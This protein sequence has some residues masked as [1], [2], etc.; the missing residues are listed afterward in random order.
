MSFRTQRHL[1]AD[2]THACRLC[3]PELR[4]CRTGVSDAAVHGL[5]AGYTTQEQIPLDPTPYQELAINQTT[6]SFLHDGIANRLN[7]E[8]KWE[9]AWAI[10]WT[11]CSTS[12]DGTD[13]DGSNTVDDYEGFH[14]RTYWFYHALTFTATKGGRQSNLTELSIGDDCSTHPGSCLQ[15]Y[16]DFGCPW[17]PGR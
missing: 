3:R 9:F 17:S 8:S 11:N 4:N 10:G 5:V 12:H 6:T 13:L 7:A 2:A 14:R 16:E 1:R 15:R